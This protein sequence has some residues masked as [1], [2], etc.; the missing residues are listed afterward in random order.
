MYQ[1]LKRYYWWNDMKREI[2]E[3]VSKCLVWQQ[4]K[5]PRQKSAGLLQPLSVPEWKW[6][7]TDGQ[8]ERLNQILED[9]LHVCAIEFSESWD[10]HLHLMEFAYDNN[11]QSSI[12]MS[13]FEVLYG[14]SCR[15]LVA[16]TKVVLRFRRKGKLGSRFIGPFKVLQRIGPVAYCL[17]L[18]PSLSSVHNIFHV[19]MLRKYVTDSPHVV[20]FKPL[21][22]NDNL[23]HREKPVEIL[24]RELKTLRYREVAFVG[25]VAESL[26]QGSYL[27][28]R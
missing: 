8:T 11:Y 15:S 9:M 10:A 22:L 24:A 4:V 19:S 5:A 16:S 26:V 3:F 7:K 28:V 14:K 20:D 13:P 21:Q 27:G 6:E 2:V 12:G 23:S 1:D 17:A 25:Y 18:P